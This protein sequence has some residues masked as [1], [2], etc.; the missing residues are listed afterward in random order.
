MVLKLNQKVFLLSPLPRSSIELMDMSTG[1]GHAK[2]FRGAGGLISPSACASGQPIGGQR[3]GH[4]H[5]L[6]D[7]LASACCGRSCPRRH[8]WRRRDLIQKS[9]RVLAEGLLC[10]AARFRV[11]IEHPRAH[12]R[13][14]QALGSSIGCDH[15]HDGAGCLCIWS[16]DLNQYGPLNQSLYATTRGRQ[17]GAFR[18]CAPSAAAI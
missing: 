13:F 10:P 11:V 16:D 15:G 17:A 1:K 5:I 3:H 12:G 7:H 18:R 6:P 4:R 8:A 14:M 2:G 9:R